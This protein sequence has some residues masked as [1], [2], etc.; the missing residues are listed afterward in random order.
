[1]SGTL[2]SYESFLALTERDR[3]DVFEAAASRLDTLPSYVE[4]DF[5]VCLFLAFPLI[6]ISFHYS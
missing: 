3:R 6:L 2:E 4:K 1:M 5:W